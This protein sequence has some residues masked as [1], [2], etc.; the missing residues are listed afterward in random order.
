MNKSHWLMI[1]LSDL[2]RFGNANVRDPVR[3]EL[4]FT[5][6]GVFTP[7]ESKPKAKMIVEKVQ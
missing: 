3:E 5:H 1:I 7:N 6:K 2:W 4:S